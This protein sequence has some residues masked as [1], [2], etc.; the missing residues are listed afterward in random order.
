MILRRFCH[1]LT[2][3][4][5]MVVYDGIDMVIKYLDLEPKIDAM[6]RGFLDPHGEKNLSKETKVLVWILEPKVV[7]W[8]LQFCTQ[9]NGVGSKEYHIVPFGELNGV[10]VA[11][12]ARFGVISKSTDRIFIS[13]GG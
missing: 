2:R 13:D 6:T 1:E 5:S 3:Q 10:P 11:L 4:W 9:T 12:V 7:E 8:E